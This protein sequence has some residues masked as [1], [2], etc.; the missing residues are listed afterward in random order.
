VAQVKIV[1]AIPFNVTNNQQVVEQFVVANIHEKGIFICQDIDKYQ[2]IQRF[3]SSMI[4]GVKPKINMYLQC[5]DLPVLERTE[6]EK[7]RREQEQSHAKETRRLFNNLLTLS[8][9]KG[10]IDLV[11]QK[12]FIIDKDF[13]EVLLELVVFFY[14]VV[15]NGFEQF[16]LY[17]GGGLL[18]EYYLII[19]RIK[20]C[21]ML[22]YLIIK[23][24]I[25]DHISI[26]IF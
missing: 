24:I 4:I 25:I 6:E 7:K 12:S 23:I 13:Q 26:F 11:D 21:M 8:S 17:R 14:R 3:I 22:I 18:K 2:T 5:L 10:F 16:T 15:F 1:K 20:N 9:K 19:I